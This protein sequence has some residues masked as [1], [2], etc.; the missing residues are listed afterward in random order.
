MRKVLKFIVI[1][2]LVLFVGLPLAAVAFVLAMAALG[3][4]IGVGGWILGIV[5]TILKVALMVVLPIAVL[6]WLATRVFARERTY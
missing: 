6:W 3:V 2:A 5:L 1:S 4:A